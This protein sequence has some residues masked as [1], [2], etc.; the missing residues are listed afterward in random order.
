MSSEQL[1]REH[2]DQ[3]ELV[4]DTRA[5]FSLRLGAC[6]P[7]QRIW[8]L[9]HHSKVCRLLRSRG[10]N[11]RCNVIVDEIEGEVVTIRLVSAAG[12]SVLEPTL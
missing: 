7:E 12:W 9:D 1:V 6:E 3:V 10:H 8:L 5:I 2:A 4:H 11:V